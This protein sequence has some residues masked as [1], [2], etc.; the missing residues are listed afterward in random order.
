MRLF[1]FVA[2][3]IVPIIEIALFLKVGSLMGIPA[4]IGL[5]I[6]T[7]IVGTMLVRS[8]G[9]DAI[10]KVQL[11]AQQ[12]KMPVE[13]ILQGFC[14]LVAGILLL[15]PGFATD[16][17]GFALLIPPIRSVIAS[18]VWNFIKPGISS[19]KSWSDPGESKEGAGIV[20]EGEAIEI[21]QKS[22]RD[23]EAENN[24]ATHH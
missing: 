6:L 13:A 24:N 16:A 11:A 12:G 18:R 7:A 15:T 19:T 4:T 21:R 10:Q 1:L 22:T 14:V 5:V 20:I 23:D 2:F 3:V 17:M 9:I 8:Q